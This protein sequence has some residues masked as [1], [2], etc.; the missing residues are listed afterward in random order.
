M[1]QLD[2]L[3]VSDTEFVGIIHKADHDKWRTLTSCLSWHLYN[4]SLIERGCVWIHG[5]DSVAF[6]K[7]IH[8]SENDDL[9][10]W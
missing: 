6:A 8:A 2:G 1:L 5:K 7:A 10:F 9:I 3:V 4:S